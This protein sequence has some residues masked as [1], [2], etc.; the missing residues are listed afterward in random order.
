MHRINNS[1]TSPL[2]SS[3]TTTLLPTLW[4]VIEVDPVPVPPEWGEGSPSVGAVPL[5]AERCPSLPLDSFRS[6]ACHLLSIA[7]HRRPLWLTLPPPSQAP[8]TLL[9]PA[10]TLVP[11]HVFVGAHGC[12][13][14]STV[15]ACYRTP[16]GSGETRKWIRTAGGL[17][18]RAFPHGVCEAYV[19]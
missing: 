13:G 1:S 7:T 4:M 16:S 18:W 5:W 10:V 19:F 17:A 2:T 15:G 14:P 12:C 11:V 8:P 6:R 9:P 3:I